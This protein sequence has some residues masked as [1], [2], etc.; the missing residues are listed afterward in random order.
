MVSYTFTVI[1]VSFFVLQWPVQSSLGKTLGCFPW[2]TAQGKKLSVP[3]L[4]CFS[5]RPLWEV[6][7][8]HIP[9]ISL[10]VYHCHWQR[11]PLSKMNASAAGVFG[12]SGRTVGET[13]I[14]IGGRRGCNLP[15]LES[16]RDKEIPGWS[17]IMILRRWWLPHPLPP[18]RLL[19]SIKLIP[20]KVTVTAT[21]ALIM[22]A[23]AAK[24]L[25]QARMKA[26]P[27]SSVFLVISGAQCWIK[28][29]QILQRG[30]LMH[31]LLRLQW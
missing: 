10:Y 25:S 8:N 23:V 12:A 2:V 26:R 3:P 31:H 29:R 16:P 5:S 6:W 9:I 11:W 13:I 7:G 20:P 21:A 17:G 14:N 15:L 27:L 19:H 22:T 24:S 1:I 30:I 18:P 4:Y 28:W